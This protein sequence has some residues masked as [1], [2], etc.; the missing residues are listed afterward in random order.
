MI[1]QSHHQTLSGWTVPDTFSITLS[2]TGVD[3]T[4]SWSYVS[5]LTYDIYLSTTGSEFI[6][7]ASSIT[8][9]SQI[10]TGRSPD[11]TYYVYVIAKNNVSDFS[12]QSATATIITPSALQ[13]PTL[14][15]SS[16]TTTTL[17]F[18][19]KA[20]T[21]AISYTLSYSTDPTLQG[22]SRASSRTVTGTSVTLSGLSNNTTYYIIIRANASHAVFNSGW[23][24]T[25][26]A[27]T[28]QPAPSTPTGFT[29]TATPG[30]IVLTW[31]D[32]AT[33]TGYRIY[34]STTDNQSTS[35]VLIELS[36][37]TITFT[38]TDVYSNTVYYYWL[39]SFH[40]DGQSGIVRATTTSHRIPMLEVR[41]T[42]STHPVVTD[43]DLTSFIQSTTTTSSGTT[44]ITFT[45]AEPE[46]IGR[47]GCL[48]QTNATSTPR[49]ACRFV[50]PLG[51][52]LT[53]T[54]SITNADTLN[55]ASAFQLSYSLTQTQYA[56]PVS[57]VTL[58]FTYS[59]SITPC[60]FSV[61]EVK[62]FGF[63]TSE[64][65]NAALS[66]KSDTELSHTFDDIVPTHVEFGHFNQTPIS[67]TIESASYTHPSSY[68]SSYNVVLS[69][70]SDATQM[71]VFPTLAEAQAKINTTIPT[72]IP[73]FSW[74]Y[75]NL[76]TEYYILLRD[77]TRY[78]I[79]KYRVNLNRPTELILLEHRIDTDTPIYSETQAVPT[80]NPVALDHLLPDNHYF[81]RFLDRSLT[82][83]P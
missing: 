67:F 35:P 54:H 36:K 81:L 63:P 62:F 29:A 19:W 66:Y 26:T 16:A 43:N 38:D 65:R 17:T 4:V 24:N 14:L 78:S 56:I 61:C 34:R 20:V 58:T 77:L 18:S 60:R 80:E 12:T 76:G 75:Q 83:F 31:K 21:E 10:L 8:S 51:T 25:V 72:F 49:V 79:Y 46:M 50:T 47:F 42:S 41:P 13:A 39:Q 11:T 33:E 71:A 57:S 9:G 82:S 48:I 44:E 28:L 3:L 15:Y 37:D 32:V 6:L 68:D 59:G 45:F 23:S 1:T 74:T 7:A 30:G 27:R 69:L 53:S 5:G 22:T 70:F 73:S 2:A 64:F 52:V 55:E 40:S